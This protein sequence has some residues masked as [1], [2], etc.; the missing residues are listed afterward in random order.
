MYHFHF[1]LYETPF[2]N[3]RFVHGELQYLVRW[4]GFTSENDTW[5]PVEHLTKCTSH[6]EAYEQSLQK[7][8]ARK[9]VA[10]SSKGRVKRNRRNSEAEDAIG[11]K[12]VKVS[13]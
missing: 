11:A 12:K 2:L 8:E 5:E 13:Q 6:I 3:R 9:D 7:A 10:Q 4:E 1:A